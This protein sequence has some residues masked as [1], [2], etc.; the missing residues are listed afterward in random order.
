MK[1]K[2]ANPL[3]LLLSWHVKSGFQVLFSLAWAGKSVGMKG[4]IS[5]I[6]HCWVFRSADAITDCAYQMS[7]GARHVSRLSFASGNAFEKSIAP[8]WSYR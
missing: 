1:T 5:Y 6:L 3:S 8:I 4:E 2:T 7:V